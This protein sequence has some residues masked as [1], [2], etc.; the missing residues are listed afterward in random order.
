MK[1]PLVD[2]KAQYRTIENEIRRAVEQ[3][4]DSGQFIMGGQG[5]LLEK[6]SA[7]FAEM[8][9]AVGVNS[10][11]DAL[12]IA[13][14]V[15][16]VGAGDEVITTTFTFVATVEAIVH[17]GAKP[18]FVD[19]DERTY[20]MDVSQIEAKVTRRTKAI[21]PVHIFGQMASMDEVCHLARKH[22]LFV[23]EDMCQSFGA[24]YGDKKAGSFAHAS[25][26]SFF[27][28]KNLGGYGDGGMVFLK[29]KKH[30]LAAK[31]MRNHG[32]ATKGMFDFVGYNSRLD[33]LQA[34]MVRVKLRHLAQWNKKRRNNAQIY[35]RHFSKLKGE[36]VLP[37]EDS[38][39]F[40]IYNLFVI[41]AKNRDKLCER[42]L[43]N[44]IMAQVHY[45]VPIHLQKAYS[46]LGYKKGDFPVSEKCCR[47]IL[48]LP[49]YPE[50][51]EEQMRFI[52]KVASGF[53]LKR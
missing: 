1:I 26:V 45:K 22:R 27:P 17:A 52:V 29:K 15:L 35:K 14:K 23:I 53:V 42:L 46:F 40:H 33:E 38:R 18:V 19:I 43:Q 31:K 10:G 5:A 41:R 32:A 8:P 36:I 25:C 39:A 9:Y 4:F 16:G 34:A 50:L 28:S 24:E 49:M 7:A 30:F 21:L 12:I 44:G 13:L 37:F 11:T 20:N 51:S 3:V 6:E 48:S 2:L 47:E